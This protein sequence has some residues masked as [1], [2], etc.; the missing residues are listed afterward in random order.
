RRSLRRGAAGG[1]DAQGWRDR[2]DGEGGLGAG[3]AVV[4]AAGEGG[5]HR[6]SV[7]IGRRATEGGAAD[8]GADVVGQDRRD[9]LQGGALAAADPGQGRCRGERLAVVGAAR[10]AH[11]HRGYRRLDGKGGGTAG[12][13]IVGAAGEEGGYQV[14]TGRAGRLV[15]EVRRGAV[16]VE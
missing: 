3:G 14:R 10:V 6:V 13:R 11:A 16:A 8:A 2:A 5:L 1:A 9:A 15:E 7:G 12:T 4:S